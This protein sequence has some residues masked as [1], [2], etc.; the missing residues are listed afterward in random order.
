MGYIPLFLTLGGF[1]FLFLMVVHQSFLSKK[2]S[3]EKNLQLTV[4]GLKLMGKNFSKP[5]SLNADGLEALEK[6]YLET[7]ASLEKEQSEKFD[8]IVKRHFQSF[9]L[10]KAQYNK[11]VEQ[12]PYSFAAKLYGHVKIA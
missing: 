12:K 3:M 5:V 6:F 7:K 8:A 9:K 2:K 1:V 10:E 4:E 11:L